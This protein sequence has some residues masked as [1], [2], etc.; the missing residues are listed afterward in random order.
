[1]RRVAPRHGILG[2]RLII[3]GAAA[4]LEFGFSRMIVQ[5]LEN[6]TDLAPFPGATI[7]TRV[8]VRRVVS[9]RVS[10]GRRCLRCRY[11]ERI[12]IDKPLAFGSTRA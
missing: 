9:V 12:G 10:V 1:M 3:G 5:L 6:A 7:V 11:S 4:S 8:S 2:I